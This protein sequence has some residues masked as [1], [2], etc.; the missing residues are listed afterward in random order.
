[1]G[2]L[3]YVRTSIISFLKSIKSLAMHNKSF[4]IGMIGLMFMLILG[5]IIS[6]FAPCNPQSWGVAPRD[7]PPS[8]KHPLGTTTTGQD[9]FWLLTYAIRNSLILGLIA[10]FVGLAIGAMLGLIAGYKGGIV[11]RII[12]FFAD[13]LNVLP[14]LPI[15]ILIS[16]LIREQLNMITLGLIIAMMTW[17]WPVRNVRS[18]ILSLRESEFTYTAIFSGYS[19]LKILLT[20]YTPYILSWIFSGA[21]NRLMGAIGMEITL[22]VFGLS[23]LER[24]TLGTMIFWALHFQALTR[25]IWWWITSPVIAV[26]ILFISLYLLSVSISEYLNPKMRLSRIAMKR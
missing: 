25:G 8:L 20:E 21:I 7:V 2:M 3:K 16:T 14:S 17:G 18:L 10:S 5:F 24:A 1:M 12:L 4:I 11:D 22:A 13:T 9:V 15:L 6:L 23:T 19:T 26:V